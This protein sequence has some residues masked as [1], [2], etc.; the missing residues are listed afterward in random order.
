MFKIGIGFDLHILVEGRSLILGGI[1]IPSELGLLGH[2]DADVLT[3]AVMDA[4]LGALG[5]GD[6]G[7]YFPPTNPEYKNI[8]SLILLKKIVNLME[9]DSCKINNLDT[10]ILAE[11]PKIMPYALRIKKKLA[12]VLKISLSQINI[13]ATT[14]EGAG[15]IGEN[16]AI[17]AQAVVLLIKKK[18]SVKR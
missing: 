14:T 5:R 11:K 9:K 8:S 10:I 2:S 16:K 18:K 15:G 1:K 3:H 17:A 4:L 7:K 13:K 6:I 12:G